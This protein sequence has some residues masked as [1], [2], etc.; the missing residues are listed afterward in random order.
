MA[1][2]IE[3]I[4]VL[5]PGHVVRKRDGEDTV[6]TLN[7]DQ[8]RSLYESLGTVNNMFDSVRAEKNTPKREGEGL[9]SE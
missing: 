6:L 1:V 5:V 8:A 9:R 3:T 2:R 4:G 7:G